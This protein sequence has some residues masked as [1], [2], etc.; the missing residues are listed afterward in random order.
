L[1]GVCM[2]DRVKIVRSREREDK[3]EE[4]PSARIRTTSQDFILIL[5][6]NQHQGLK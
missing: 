1:I 2:N 4:G 3:W 6:D 5:A